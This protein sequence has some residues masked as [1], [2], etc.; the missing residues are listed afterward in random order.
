MI[1]KEK[2]SGYALLFTLLFIVLLTSAVIAIIAASSADSRLQRSTENSAVSYQLA[3]QG[4]EDGWTLYKANR[5]NSLTLPSVHELPTNACLATSSAVTRNYPNDSSKTPE[6]VT[7]QTKVNLADSVKGVYDFKICDDIIYAIGYSSG[8]KITLKATVD[9]S[10]DE[11]NKDASGNSP[12]G[13]PA[14]QQPCVRSH[15]NDTI[16]ITQIG[17]LK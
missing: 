6:P 12:C 15:L 13:G 10:I 17:P 14:P 4:V 7:V 11:I 2:H 1:L 8:N 3:K 9:H 5:T 16:S